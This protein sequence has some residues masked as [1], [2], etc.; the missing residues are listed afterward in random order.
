MISVFFAID[1]EILSLECGDMCLKQFQGTF[2][3]TSALPMYR[4]CIAN[5]NDE[6]GK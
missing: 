6:I 1:I 3:E 2:T 5:C 4:Q